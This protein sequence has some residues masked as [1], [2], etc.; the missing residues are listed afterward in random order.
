MGAIPYEGGTTFRV[1]AP[2]A[3]SVHVAGTFNR[4]SDSAHTLAGEGNGYWSA[5]VAQAKS[6]DEYKYVMTYGPQKLWRIDPYAKDVTNSVGNSIIVESAHD[7]GDAVF[8]MPPWNELVLYEMHVGTFNDRPGGKPGD[9]SGVIAKLPY[10]R[11]LGINAIQIM[12]P[13][14][15]AG[16]FSWGY[17]PANIFAIEQ[18]YGGPRELKRLISA[19]H[20][21]GIAVLFDVVY[22]HLGPSDLNLWQFDGWHENNRGGIYFYNDWRCATP[23]GETRP[24]YGRAEVRRYLRDNALM[25]LEEYR[26]D[27]LRWDATAYIR[28]VSGGGDPAH[29][30]ADG[31]GLMQWINDEIKA[32]QPW[33]ISIAEDLRGNEWLTKN[34]GG[35]AGFDA[36][37]DANFV[38]PIRRAIIGANDHDRDMY[39]VRDAILSRYNGDAFERVIYTESHDEVANGKARVPQEIWPGNAGSYFSK[40]RS[41]LG[42]VLVFC[43][44]GIPMLF[45]GQE[46]LEDE[47]FRDTD[48]LD[49]KKKRRY[50]GI[51]RLYRD[52]IRLRR[53]WSDGTRGLRGQHV[54]VFHVN[55]QDKVIAFHR[56]EHGGPGDD[57]V[58]V[59]NMAD[60]AYDAYTIG[61]PRSGLWTVR[62][63]SDWRG[64][65]ED[66]NNQPSLDTM[67]EPGERDGLPSHGSL[68]LGR[69][70]AVIL[71]QER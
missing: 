1:W 28:N 59:V 35:G 13:M 61:F 45:Q 65:S 6:G 60:R 54:H 53:N 2:F 27:G 12:P 56:W 22:N 36:Q 38:H 71:S 20:A 48:P 51:V 37:W 68:G 17:N 23:W 14:E 7:W 50:G 66:F 52:L 10:L 42:A 62:F 3:S 58:V 31:W 63:N 57:V 16:G 4:W 67:A 15:F 33:K 43:S 39:S 18:D 5:D 69:Y 64:Y 34:S 49:W 32:R 29:D 26:I 9:L 21:H 70:S 24:D 8:H 19:A 41:T 46:F 25:W 40:K 11:D 55:N 44:P 47:W 30:L